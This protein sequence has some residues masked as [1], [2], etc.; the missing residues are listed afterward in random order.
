MIC[1]SKMI[2]G[3][4]ALALLGVFHTIPGWTFG[5]EGIKFRGVLRTLLAGVRIEAMGGIFQGVSEMQF[6]IFGKKTEL[7]RKRRA[8]TG[9]GSGLAAIGP[10]QL[11]LVVN[12]K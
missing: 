7:M 8:W 3:I 1:E 12:L 9:A 2:S 6:W 4:Q 5:W 10:V 11:V